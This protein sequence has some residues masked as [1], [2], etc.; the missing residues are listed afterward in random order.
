M[1]RIIHS[2]KLAHRN[3]P[4]IL[5]GGRNWFEM[6]TIS[7]FQTIVLQRNRRRRWIKLNCKRMPC[8]SVR[9]DTIS[10]LSNNMFLRNRRQTQ[11]LILQPF[12][13]DLI[14]EPYGLCRI[15]VVTTSVADQLCKRRWLN[16]FRRV[17]KVLRRRWTLHIQIKAIW[18][19]PYRMNRLKWMSRMNKWNCNMQKFSRSCLKPL[20]YVTQI[21]STVS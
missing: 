21:A 15:Q 12:V 14:K 11:R 20:V 13:V 2:Q 3:L 17:Y 18:M 19:L 7:S 10:K 4:R 16:L 9:I 5:R 8:V 6:Q 1:T